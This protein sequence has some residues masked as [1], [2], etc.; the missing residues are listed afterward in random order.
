MENYW[1]SGFFENIWNSWKF[2]MKKQPG[3]IDA[4][5][6]SQ[7]VFCQ[8]SSLTRWPNEDLKY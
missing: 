5:G 6:V 4:W 1:S 3:D 2:D 8:G 7:G